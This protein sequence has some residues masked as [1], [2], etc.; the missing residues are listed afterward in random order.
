MECALADNNVND[1]NGLTCNKECE[2]GMKSLHRTCVKCTSSNCHEADGPKLMIRPLNH[3][4]THFSIKPNKR[5]RESKLDWAKTT[6]ISLEP[7][8]LPG[9]YTYKLKVISPGVMNLRIHADKDAKNQNLTIAL[10]NST[11]IADLEGNRMHQTT[12]RY[13]LKFV[14]YYSPIQRGF[15]RFLADLSKPQPTI[16]QNFLFC[17]S[18]NFLKQSTHLLELQS[19]HSCSTSSDSSSR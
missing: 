1:Y 4:K 10:T 19:S 7:D 8:Y 11:E 9:E 16:F 13:L 12:S 3:I 18:T 2:K 17:I 6:M 14:D 15:I 5:L